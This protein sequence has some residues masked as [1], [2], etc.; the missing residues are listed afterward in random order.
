LA[1]ITLTDGRTY[2]FEQWGDPARRPG[3]RVR[4]GPLSGL[5]AQLPDA[6]E[7]DREWFSRPQ[8][9]Q[10]MAESLAD[11]A[12]APRSAVE[13]VAST[14]PGAELTSWHGQG[15]SAPSRNAEQ[16]LTELAATLAAGASQMAA[17]LR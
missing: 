3:P 1:T 17:G 11:D 13:R 7:Q 14:I 9:Q 15:H 6:P 12:N 10:I 2:A 4:A 8:V 16:V 5:L